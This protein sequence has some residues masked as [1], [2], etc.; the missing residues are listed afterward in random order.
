MGGKGVLPLVEAQEFARA[1][2]HSAC[3]MENVHRPASQAGSLSAKAEN[4]FHEGIA[5]DFGK[6]IKAALQPV[7]K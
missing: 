3:D 4:T 6:G 1:D 2:F 7:F 5:I